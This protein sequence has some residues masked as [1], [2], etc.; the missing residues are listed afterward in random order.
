MQ[1]SAVWVNTKSLPQETK[2]QIKRLHH[3]TLQVRETHGLFPQSNKIFSSYFKEGTQ[4]YA[5]Y[6]Q[7]VAIGDR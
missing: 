7:G 1:P 6:K 2:G 3:E 4:I 5:T